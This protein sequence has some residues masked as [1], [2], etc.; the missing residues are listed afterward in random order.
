MD[1]LNLG[2]ASRFDEED[3]RPNHAISRKKQRR[4]RRG[5]G[6]EKPLPDYEGEEEAPEMEDLADIDEAE[7]E[8]EEDDAFKDLVRRMAGGSASEGRDRELPRRKRRFGNDSLRAE[9]ED[10]M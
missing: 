5:V 8:I 4:F 3:P 2:L 1:E 7:A 9:F 10:R 6:M